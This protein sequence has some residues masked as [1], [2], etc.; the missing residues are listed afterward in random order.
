MRAVVNGIGIRFDVTGPD[1]GPAVMLLHGFPDTG[2]L[3]RHQVPALAEAGFRVVVPDLR[4][5]GGSD[6]PAEVEA[7]DFPNLVADVLG[8]LHHLGIHRTH[9]VGHDWGAALGWVTAAVAPARVQNLVALTVGHPMSFRTTGFEQYQRSW[10]I[11]LFQFPWVAEQWLSRHG[12][13]NFRRWA[14]HPDADAVIADLE[15]TGSLTPGLN[16]YRA[17]VLP[18]SWISPPVD[19]PAVEAPTLGVWASGDRFLTEAQMVGSEKYVRGEWRYERVDGAGHWLQL[20]APER[21]NDLLLGFLP[22]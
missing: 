19:L 9:V 3:W 15:E 1:D 22:A 6:K 14:G 5:Y 12:W 7:Y 20:D 10:Y 2:R 11:L 13:A 4:G 16:Y 21:V 18:K 17:N 8:V